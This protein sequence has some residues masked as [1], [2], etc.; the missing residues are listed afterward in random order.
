MRVL[1][2]ILLIPVV[3]GWSVT[4]SVAE[5]AAAPTTPDYLP[6]PTSETSSASAPVCGAK[7]HCKDMATCAEAY[8]YM[9]SCG[10]SDLDRDADGIPCETICGKTLTT[11]QGRIKAH[12]Y[13]PVGFAATSKP[14]SSAAQALFGGAT[15]PAPEPTFDCK[16]RKTTCKQML[17]CEEATFYLQNCGVSRLDGNNDGVPCNGLCR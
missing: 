7:Q 2:L 10:L 9:T 5:D 15:I 3:V 8:F 4:A 1:S 6:G 16:V 12:P 14:A 11:M 17:S 13:V